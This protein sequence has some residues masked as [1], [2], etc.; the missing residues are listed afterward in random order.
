MC[1]NRISE[2]ILGVHGR[3]VSQTEKNLFLFVFINSKN[4]SNKKNM[5]DK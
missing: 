1:H 2:L 4:D 3:F 5:N